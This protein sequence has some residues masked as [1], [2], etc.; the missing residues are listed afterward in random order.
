MYNRDNPFFDLLN[1]LASLQFKGNAFQPMPS[2]DLINQLSNRETIERLYQSR[3]N[4]EAQVTSTS[5]STK[6]HSF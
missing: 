6:P 5:P 4:L 3:L 2:M 1:P